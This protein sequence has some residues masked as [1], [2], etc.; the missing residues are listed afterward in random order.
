MLL[1]RLGLVPLAL[2]AAAVLGTCASGA[3]VPPLQLTA[4]DDPFTGSDPGDGPPRVAVAEWDF[5]ANAEGWTSPDECGDK[6]FHKEGDVSWA[7]NVFAPGDGKLRL[8]LDFDGQTEGGSYGGVPVEFALTTPLE[9]TGATFVQFDFYY[10]MD[11]RDILMRFELWSPVTG[12]PAKTHEYVVS[13]SLD[14]L[15]GPEGGEI[16]GLTYRYKTLTMKTNPTSGT[17]DTVRLDLHGEATNP[18]YKGSL[19][20]DNVRI[21]QEDA[22]EPIPTVVNTHAGADLP[23]LAGRYEKEF[24]IGFFGGKVEGPLVGQFV[25]WAPGNMLKADTVHP[26]APAWL[27]E[28]Y[29]ELADL[30]GTPDAPEYNFAPA[31]ELLDMARAANYKLHG[32]VLAWYNQGAAWM[33]RLIPEHVTSTIPSLDGDYYSTGSAAAPPYVRVNKDDAR[34][35]YYEHI[36]TVMRYY[37]EKGIAFYSWDVLNEEIQG[38]RHADL[39]AK[40]ENEWRSALW[41]TSWLR[42]MTDD[43]FGD[44]RQH[45]V[46]LLFKYAHIAVP[47]AAMAKKFKTAPLPPWMEAGKDKIDAMV[48]DTPPVLYFNEYGLDSPTKARVAYNMVKELNAA[49]KGDPLYD[50]RN[51]IEGIALQGQYHVG[52]EMAP[53][54]RAALKLFSSLVDQKLLTTL[55]MS[56]LNL[57]LGESA[58]GGSANSGTQALNQKQADAVGYQYALLFSA[59][60]DYRK[61]IERV[62][63]GGKQ[64]PAGWVLFD[65]EANANP[66]WF[67]AWDPARFIKG[68]SYLSPYFESKR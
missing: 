35:A 45:F 41:N 32:H 22:G 17:W 11:T 54:V 60:H 55:S 19:F 16:N 28:K 68:H 26:R 49:W 57:T 21:L 10:P 66:A 12:Q 1:K 38:T 39:I 5:D 8:S 31:D 34:R 65:R 37:A 14:Y 13:G 30:A 50:G 15:N 51:L 61:Y 3:K 63:V 2:L 25:E 47:N 4:G 43:D 52:P 42:A 7:A 59:F 27:A 44:V 36:T 6:R 58:P 48:T 18:V 46:Y 53:N 20:I 56:E 24:I 9:L 29:A 67:A 40:N 64:D 62:C 33:K 23:P